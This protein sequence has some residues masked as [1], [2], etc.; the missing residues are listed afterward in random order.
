MN[1]VSPIFARAGVRAVSQLARANLGAGAHPR[2]SIAGGSFALVD[3]AGT[4]YQAPIVLR[5]NIPTLQV[6]I[7]NANENMSKVY[8]E[9]EYDPD[10]GTPPTCFS[11]NG[12]GPSK[13]ASVKQART[14]AECPMNE[15]GSATSRLTGKGI[16]ACND[17]KKLA[18]LVVGDASGLVYELQIPPASLKVLG[19]YSSD[20]GSY[21]APGTD[22]PAD[23][24]D[25]VT[26]LQFVPGQTGQLQF[27][28]LAFLDAVNVDEQGAS[29]I[30]YD[31]RNAPQPAQ[32][33]G[34]AVA[35]RIDAAWDSGQADEVVGNKDVAYT[36][37]IAA[38]VQH[39]QAYLEPQPQGGALQ[40]GSHPQQ[41]APS[42]QHA[43]ATP[44]S[45]QPG[46]QP[47]TPV[48]AFQPPPTPADKGR[49][50]GWTAGGSPTQ[51]ETTSKRGRGG[52]RAGAGRPP[53]AVAG[54]QEVQQPAAVPFPTGQRPVANAGA[55][56][57]GDDDGAVAEAPAFL[58]RATT[59]GAPVTNGNFGM[60]EA[61]KPAVGVMD[62]VRAAMGLKT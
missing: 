61:G 15:W 52:P 54:P 9:G 23:L 6:I 42:V 1:E 46:Q 48:R 30:D 38:P 2:I 51:E 28:P 57:G 60:Q 33:G 41:V 26:G 7:V 24:S 58:N 44:W 59:A 17:K 56:P 32:D 50:D 21:T 55:V 31:A 20:I 3:G 11:D 19:K 49:N 37:A 5:Q 39:A 45:G 35:Q 22:R 43:P 53:K 14:C 18:V 36:G 27:V 29:W 16:K 8:F 4:R 62:A 40:R 47:A 13:N 34:W 12:V 25:M 10:Q